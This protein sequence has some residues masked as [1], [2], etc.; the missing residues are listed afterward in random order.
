MSCL[1][2]GAVRVADRLCDMHLKDG[3]RLAWSEWGAPE[4]TPVLFVTGAGMS[5][6]FG[7]G[8]DV[9]EQ[10]GLRL[11]VPDRASLGRSDMDP[12]KT[13]LSVS[14]DLAELSMTLGFSKLPV[15]AFSQGAPFALAFAS[16]GYASFLA[17]VS[18]QDELSHPD[19]VALLPDEVRQ[20]VLQAER[21]PKGFLDAVEGFAKPDGFFEMIL[22]MS[23][24]TDRAIYGEKGFAAAYRQALREGFAQGP[25]GYAR[26]TLAAF[27]P[28]PFRLE[29][30]QC[31]VTLW[32][33]A[34][35]TSPVHSPDFGAALARRLPRAT[36]NLIPGSGSA[37]LWTHAGEI[38]ESVAQ[39][40][41]IG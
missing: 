12:S 28:W 33:G 13:L 37:L 34:E 21:D 39:A 5:G 23:S 1:S 15:V 14:R 11:V 30:I 16:Q 6:F 4:G 7:F 22:A 25:K 19:A 31:P 9:L 35:D 10:H 38:L 8:F 29:Q 32:Y 3:R 27:R 40:G 18:G 24:E 26:D 17:I 2:S 20:M 41:S 36:H